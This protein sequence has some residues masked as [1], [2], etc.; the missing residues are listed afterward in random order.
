MSQHHGIVVLLVT[1]AENKRDRAFAS[2]ATQF[3][4][5]VRYDA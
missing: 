1:R 5:L 3:I 2:E 4:E